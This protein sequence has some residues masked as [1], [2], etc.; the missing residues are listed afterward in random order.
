MGKLITIPNAKNSFSMKVKDTEA[1]ILLYS[2]IG[3]SMWED[4]VSAKQFSEELNKLPANVKNITLRVNSPGGSVFDGLSI[5]ERLKQHKAKVTVY[6]DGLAAS[7]ASIIALAGDEIVIGEGSFFM[8]HAPMAGVQGNASE[9]QEMID[10]LDKIEN[11]MIG[12]Y[13]RK[14]KLS[15]AEISKM[16]MKDT[17]INS[18]EAISMGFADRLSNESTEAMAIA[19]SMLDKAEWIKS[20]PDIKSHDAVA[21]EKVREFKN[22]V[23]EFLARK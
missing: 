5:Y 16:L 17:W 11:Q 3:E 19:A 10:V 13:A 22:N 12:I 15:T 23:K 7:I 1:T 9:M 20:R 2:S 8:V 14:T 21:R 4:S 18:E 6:V